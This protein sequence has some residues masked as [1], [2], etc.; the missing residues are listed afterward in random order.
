MFRAQRN[1]SESMT[2]TCFG[3]K[4]GNPGSRGERLGYVVDVTKELDREA[5]GVAAVICSDL[6]IVSLQILRR[7]AMSGIFSVF[8]RLC[9][10]LT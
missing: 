8:S 9:G 4:S 1:V 2:S 7:V 5:P 6:L 10:A 3:A